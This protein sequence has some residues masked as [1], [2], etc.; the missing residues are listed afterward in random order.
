MITVECCLLVFGTR[1]RKMTAGLWKGVNISFAF[2]F[3]FSEKIMKLNMP[4]SSCAQFFTNISMKKSKHVSMMES[5]SKYHLSRSWKKLFLTFCFI[6]RTVN[7]KNW[8]CF[9][10]NFFGRGIIY[11]WYTLSVDFSGITVGGIKCN[12]KCRH[13]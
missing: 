7:N 8:E 3:L 6:W 11:H 10:P 9:Q 4:N 13:V 2:I 1:M 12:I 5:K